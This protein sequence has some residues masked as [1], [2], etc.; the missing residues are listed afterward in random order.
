MRPFL[1]TL[2]AF[3]ALLSTPLRAD[4]L[5]PPPGNYAGHH[6][7]HDLKYEVHFHFDGVHVQSVRLVI[8]GHLKHLN[9]VRQ[10]GHTFVAHNGTYEVDGSF[11]LNN[12]SVHCEIIHLSKP[13]QRLGSLQ[14]HHQ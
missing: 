1:W 6:I 9:D 4:E 2:L 11:L 3:T 14:A 10:T 13:K 5:N 8:A 12:R 7:L